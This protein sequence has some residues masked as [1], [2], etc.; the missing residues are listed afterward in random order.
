[1]S[2]VQITDLKGYSSSFTLCFILKFVTIGIGICVNTLH[3]GCEK[4]SQ[5]ASRPLPLH[6][7]LT[8]CQRLSVISDDWQ[9]IGAPPTHPSVKILTRVG[10]SPNLWQGGVVAKKRP[11]GRA[12]EEKGEI[13]RLLKSLNSGVG[14]RTVPR[15]DL[16]R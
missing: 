6:D 15:E 5:K 13:W 11:A 10:R 8:S 9:P 16:K 4:K 2:Q 7:W 3:I 1:M 12:H 14:W